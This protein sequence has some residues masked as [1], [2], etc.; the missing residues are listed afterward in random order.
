MGKK[1]R[2]AGWLMT[3]ALAITLLTA[4][5]RPLFLPEPLA[6]KE[7]QT[8]TPCA[9]LLLE[10]ANQAG[11]PASAANITVDQKEVNQ[12]DAA[13]VLYYALEDDSGNTIWILDMHLYIV[14]IQCA[15]VKQNW[16]TADWKPNTTF[17]GYEAHIAREDSGYWDEVG[18]VWCMEKTDIAHDIRVFT[19]TYKGSELP[20]AAPNR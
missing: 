11:V 2:F 16:W 17:H 10:A 12:P 3:G 14:D 13:C 19:Q 1:L 15:D 7:F 9:T 4:A 8:L 5:S 6:G 18:V 20:D